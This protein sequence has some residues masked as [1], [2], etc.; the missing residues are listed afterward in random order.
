[1]GET[2][3][4]TFGIVFVA[5]AASCSGPEPGVE[6]AALL[7][8][9]T[10][11]QWGQ[12]AQHAGF[13]PVVGQAFKTTYLNY[14][15]DTLVQAQ[16]DA[17]GG[18]LLVH[19]MTPLTESDAV[20]MET[21]GGAYN[22]NSYAAQTWGVVKFKWV[23]GQLVQQWQV[24]SDWKA[25]GTNQNDFWEPVFH[26]ALA[27]GYL[28]V[29]GGRGTILK[30]S[31]ADGSVVSRISAV[32]NNDSNTYTTSPL[33]VD[34]SGNLY[35]TALRMPAQG[36]QKVRPLDDIVP[37]HRNPSRWNAPRGSFFYGRDALDSYLIKV[38]PS[39]AAQAV[40]IS[41]LVPDAPKSSD[42]C[43]T[44][45]SE[46]DL[47]WPPSPD[48]VPPTTNCGTQ[49]VALNAA[50][51]LSPDGS[52]IYIITRAHFV[53][54]YN[55]LV[56]V[57]SDLT[58]KWDSS[59]RDRLNDGCGVPVAQGGQLE[60]NG[61]PNGCRVG[62]NYGV[63]PQTNRP[64]AGR[65][66]DD[67]SSS[68]AV[69]PDGSIYFGA[70]TSYNYFQGHLM[71]FDANGNFLNSYGFGWDT[72]PAFFV[73]D[74]TFSVITKDNH[75][76]DSAAYCFNDPFWCNA[77]RNTVSP[78]YPEAYYITQLSPDL[79]VEWQYRSTNQ[80]SCSRDA[81]NNVTC[82]TTGDHTPG[83]EWCVNAPAVDS[84][85]TVFVNSEDGWLY[86]IGQGGK[87][88]DKIFQQLAVGAAYTPAS[89]GTD[90]KIYSQ[91]SG[92]LFVIGK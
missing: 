55:Y 35:F 34:A 4:R 67:E 12:N 70:Y 58:P 88:K 89:L 27:N 28:Y 42:N 50:P 82:V 80:Q 47:P 20:Y 40:S 75:Y 26:G 56:A 85:G 10:W 86:A 76:G 74:G 48:A 11:P 69:A 29:P 6:S 5:L 92:H 13:L 37:S 84:N 78:D 1:M 33:T 44:I 41:T 73:H 30:L 59:L 17:S 16:L 18:D 90:G 63:D 15:Y 45:F 39:D 9:P 52:T 46:T 36:P 43:Y 51:A 2:M 23:G 57:N 79:K 54:R 14:T 31:K 77:D 62:A 81:N 32:P 22:I 87:V 38:A 71:H 66:L 24:N 21:K 72:T 3:K 25:A 64:G 83:F 65:V 60:P 53:T 61:V 91:N 19:Y 8:G 68:P 7:T 49:R